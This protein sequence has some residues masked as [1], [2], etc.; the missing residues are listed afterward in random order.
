MVDSRQFALIHMSINFGRG[1]IRMA[2]HLLNGP[3]IGTV[4]KQMAGETVAQS[5]R[6]NIFGDPRPECG[7]LDDRPY[8]FPVQF[9]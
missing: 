7:V 3:Q 6:I 2:Q 1:N 9:P 5:V 4:G 8:P